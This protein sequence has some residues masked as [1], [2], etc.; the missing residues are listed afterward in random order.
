MALRKRYCEMCDEF[1]ESTPNV[2]CPKCGDR[3][4]PVE[5]NVKTLADVWAEEDERDEQEATR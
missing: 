5:K 4:R 3:T 1:F 2:E